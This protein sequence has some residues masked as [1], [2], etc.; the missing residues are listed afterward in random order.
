MSAVGGLERPPGA[1]AP[2]WLPDPSG[3]HDFRWF[4]GDVWTA[5]VADDGH[6]GFDPDLSPRPPASPS[7]GRAAALTSLTLAVI[8]VAISWMPF[9][10]VLGVAAAMS[11]IVLGIVALARLQPGPGSGRRLA[12]GGIIC[13][14]AALGLSGIGMR[15]SNSLLDELRTTRDPGPYVARLVTCLVDPEGRAVAAGEIRNSG[16]S[17]RAYVVTVTFG[18]AA[19]DFADRSTRV[20]VVDPGETASFELSTSAGRTPDDALTCRIDQVSSPTFVLGDS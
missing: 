12:A 14:V 1:A 4:N 9:V 10:V 3:R 13:S 8:A 17:P 6:R 20:A 18:D 19:S 16:D 7:R 11:A 15:S 2:G 5:D